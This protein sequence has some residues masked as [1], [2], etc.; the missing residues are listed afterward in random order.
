LPYSEQ[1]ITSV[2]RWSPKTF[3]FTATRPEG[4]EFENGQFVTLGLRREGKLIPRA[5]SIVSDP[6]NRTSSSSASTCPMAS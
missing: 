1:S 6:A 5:Y 4:F 3:S 2:R